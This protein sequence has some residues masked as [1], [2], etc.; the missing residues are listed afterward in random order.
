MDNLAKLEDLTRRLGQPKGN[1]DLNVKTGEL[2]WSTTVFRMFG[3]TTDMFGKTYQAFLDTVHEDDRASVRDAVDKALTECA[4]YSI[5]H[6]IVLPDG[7]IRTV[8]EEAEVFFDED[9]KAIRMT[10]TVQ[11]ITEFGENSEVEFRRFLIEEIR[12]VRKMAMENTID[13]AVV[14]SMARKSGAVGATLPVGL[15]GLIYLI[16][17]VLEKLG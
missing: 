16:T 3:L 17:L 2:L 6:R 13:M 8:H 14:K 5:S 1:W 4:E 9:G 10:G 12:D 11:D 15:G 7:R